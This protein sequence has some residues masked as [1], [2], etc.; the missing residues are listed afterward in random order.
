MQQM[1]GRDAYLD[2][3]LVRVEQPMKR[4][5]DWVAKSF[6]VVVF[7]ASA[8]AATQKKKAPGANQG[9]LIGGASELLGRTRF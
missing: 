4:W 6:L 1:P 8:T 7:F 3:L 9:D 5:S 2:G